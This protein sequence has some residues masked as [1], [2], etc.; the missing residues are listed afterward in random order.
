[1][2]CSDR[3]FAGVITSGFCG[4]LQTPSLFS[5]LNPL[6][7]FGDRCELIARLHGYD[8]DSPDN[9]GFREGCHPF[10]ASSG[11]YPKLMNAL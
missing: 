4:E 11:C 7:H 8:A 1:M 2:H 10:L 9:E 3:R 6:Y 5:K